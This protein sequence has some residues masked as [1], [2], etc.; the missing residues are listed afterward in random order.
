MDKK[1]SE[2]INL[3]QETD[4]ELRRR[5]AAI[6]ESYKAL[7]FAG[8]D[9]PLFVE[10]WTPS[11]AAAPYVFDRYEIKGNQVSLYGVWSADCFINTISVSF[12]ISLIDDDKAIGEFLRE[13]SARNKARMEQEREAAKQSSR[14]TTQTIGT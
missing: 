3:Q 13:Q 8:R 9:D 5:C 14:I 11:T 1:T 7:A 2:L 10:M 6:F 4:A 12:P